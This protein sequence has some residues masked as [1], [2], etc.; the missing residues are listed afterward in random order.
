MVADKEITSGYI[1]I[2]PGMVAGVKQ[3][4]K[5]YINGEE[6]ITL[7]FV[8]TVGQNDPADV[9]EIDGQPKIK[10]IIPGGINGDVATCAIAVNAIGS[11]ISAEP[12]LRT[13]ADVP[14]ITF[15]STLT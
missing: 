1:P 4:G 2:K 9:V 14:P 6:V 10:S 3:T 11:I 13:M 5:G 8:A 15:F 7:E 12:G